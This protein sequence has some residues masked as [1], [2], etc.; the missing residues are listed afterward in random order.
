MAWS[1][2]AALIF[3]LAIAASPVKNALDLE[4]L[5]LKLAP[6]TVVVHASVGEEGS[7]V[8]DTG[9]GVLLDGGYVLTACHVLEVD[10]VQ[11]D[12]ARIR[13]GDQR[14]EGMVR[15]GSTVDAK[16]IRCDR[17]R[18]LALLK[19]AKPVV[20]RALELAK[21]NP[22]P[23][24]RT[25]AIGP[26]SNGFPWSVHECTIGGLGRLNMHSAELL[27]KITTEPDALPSVLVLDVACV[28]GQPLSGSAV[29][30]RRGRIL[31]IKQFRRYTTSAES[32]TGRHFFIA[33]SEIR[34]FL[35]E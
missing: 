15:A 32:Q 18:D 20:A 29:F 7:I 27:G 26:T 19:P 17:E 11:V 23:G 3:E 22:R 21:S 4:A 12:H 6:S 2:A 16:V 35:D 10:G 31:G 30:D 24:A 5:Y 9:G 28:G 13:F 14:S 1:E 33:A 25:M 8:E 34:A